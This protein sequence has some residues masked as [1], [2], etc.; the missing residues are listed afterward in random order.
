MN[1]SIVIIGAGGHGKVIADIIQK[2]GDIVKGFLDDAFE[3][4]ENFIGFPVLG[5]VRDYKNYIE[6]QFIVAIGNAEIRERIVA[7][8]VKVHWYTAIHPDAVIAGFD[9]SIGEG[10][11]VMANAVVNAGTKVGKHCIINSSAVVEH[12]NII[13]DFVHVS[14]GAKLAGTVHI[15]KRTWIGIGATVSNNL[16]ICQDCMIGAGAVVVKN[17]NKVGTYMG[18]PA[19]RVEMKKKV[20]SNNL[21][22]GGRPCLIFNNWKYSLY[23]DFLEEKR[24]AV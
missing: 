1:K 4:D 19:E 18:V 5:K 8:M 20:I 3:I 2:S 13:E 23:A 9:T 24:Y 6:N 16:N 12:D 17:V 15:G 22:G 14:V 10:S 11:A 21:L 7:K